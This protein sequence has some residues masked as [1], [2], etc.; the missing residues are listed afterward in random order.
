LAGASTTC[1]RYGTT[2]SACAA[3]RGQKQCRRDDYSWCCAEG[4]EYC[5]TK[6]GICLPE[7]AVFA[8]PLAQDA[9]ASAFAST[10]TVGVPA[11][12]TTTTTTATTTEADAT[13]TATTTTTTVPIETALVGVR[14]ERM[15][16]AAV[17]GV[18][19]GVTAGVMLV[20]AVG[21]FLGRQWQRRSRYREDAGEKMLVKPQRVSVESLD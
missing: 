3:A 7:P 1:W 17:V 9:P 6:N 11:T 21:W 15:S 13:T 5:D 12:E 2:S 16:T 18:G 20:G 10:F 19:V 8:N 14:Q 4:L